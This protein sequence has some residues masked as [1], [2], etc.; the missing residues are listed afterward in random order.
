VFGPCSRLLLLLTLTFSLALN[1]GAKGSAA[2][3]SP[4]LS[5]DLIL[6]IASPQTGQQLQGR[7]EIRGYAIDRRS[8]EA[9]GINPRDVQV[10]LGDVSDPRNLLDYARTGVSS[11]EATEAF[12]SQFSN[13]G[14]VATWETCSFPAGSYS[15]TIWVSSL[16]VPGERAS[17]TIPISIDPCSPGTVIDSPTFT[18]GPQS[19]RAADGFH[20]TQG[21]SPGFVTLRVEPGGTDS[22]IAYRFPSIYADFAVGLDARCTQIIMTCLYNLFVRDTP[23]PGG[24]ETNGVYYLQ[25]RPNTGVYT[26]GYTA[27]AAEADA[28]DERFTP[29]VPVTQSSAIRRGL[30]TNR[31]AAIAQGDR[32]RF[33]INSQE[34]GDFHDDH[35]PWGRVGVSLRTA[36]VPRAPV[37][38]LVTN[39]VT[40]VP[41][42]VDSLARVLRPTNT[43]SRSGPAG[44]EDQVVLRDNFTDPNSGWPRESSDPTNWVVGYASG[45]YY[46]RRP[47]SSRSTPGFYTSQW[48][49]DVSL[50]IDARVEP[51]EARPSAILLLRRRADGDAYGLW[52]TPQ[53]SVVALGRRTNGQWSTLSQQRNVRGLNAG[54]AWNRLGVR[55]RGP[56][57]VALVNGEEVTRVRD[58]ALNDGAVGFG[59]LQGQAGPVDMYYRN[60]VI[61]SGDQ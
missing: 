50:E 18:T 12:G 46:I 45:E 33:F 22:G 60:L 57:L 38:V 7:V 49:R 16:V 20:T 61:T 17:T 53:S 19:T 1:S 47:S 9:S 15:L 44:G 27:S 40:M 52:V 14:F 23:G 28:P 42:P 4:Q 25:V 51:S 54:N 26:I 36:S 48:F 55:A 3:S 5:D 21:G 2:T 58:E 13:A 24:G 34:V 41:G 11:P 35:L 32:L 30:E 10:W 29:I 56:E 39:V 8:R 37:E 43:E 31:L 6:S 59:V